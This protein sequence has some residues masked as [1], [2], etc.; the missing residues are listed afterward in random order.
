MFISYC[1]YLSINYI[2]TLF[3][4]AK[5]S[6]ICYFTVLRAK[7]VCI[8]FSCMILGNIKS[9]RHVDKFLDAKRLLYIILSVGP[10]VPLRTYLLPYEMQHLARLERVLLIELVSW[11]ICFTNELKCWIYYYSLFL[12][13]LQ[14]LSCRNTKFIMGDKVSVIIYHNFKDRNVVYSTSLREYV[15]QITI[16]WKNS[17]EKIWK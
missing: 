4:I 15:F 2:N 7:K 1:L 13:F 16:R 5:I 11:W 9:C 3:C 6:A 17:W 14:L 12:L 8:D 10:Y